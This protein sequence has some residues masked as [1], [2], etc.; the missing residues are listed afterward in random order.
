MARTIIG[1]LNEEY[2]EGAKLFNNWTNAVTAHLKGDKH[3]K[4]KS[5]KKSKTRRWN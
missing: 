5:C 1:W 3:G 4:N 2:K